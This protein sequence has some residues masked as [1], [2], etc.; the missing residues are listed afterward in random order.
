MGNQGEGLNST[1]AWFR[2]LALIK[3]GSADL[4][5]Q[6][7]FDNRPRSRDREILLLDSGFTMGNLVRIESFQF[8]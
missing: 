3:Q 6:L 8:D 2:S 7:L 5:H 1:D 4:R